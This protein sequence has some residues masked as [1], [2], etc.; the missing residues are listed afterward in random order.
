MWYVTDKERKLGVCSLGFGFLEAYVVC[1]QLG[2]P[3]LIGLSQA[4]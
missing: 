1:N 3:K 2:L 4:M